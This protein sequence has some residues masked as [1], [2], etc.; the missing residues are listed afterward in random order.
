MGY[1]FA[2][3]VGNRNKVSFLI[4]CQRD[5]VPERSAFDIGHKRFGGL[6]IAQLA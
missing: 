6:S 2:C 3:L 4:E 1:Q 5:S